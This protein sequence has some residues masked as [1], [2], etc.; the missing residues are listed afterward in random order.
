MQEHILFVVNSYPP[1]LGG[2]EKHVAS[3]AQ[4]IVAQG[5]R[6]TV[7]S[8]HDIPSDGYSSGVRV[9]TR[10]GHLNIGSVFSFP[11]LGTKKLIKELISS[12]NVTGVS[13]H[14]RFFPMSWL[15]ICAAQ[16][17]NIP[18]VITEHGSNFVTGAKRF[19]LLASRIIDWTMGRWALRRANQVLAISNE[20][21]SFVKKLSGRKAIIFNNAVETDFWH[22]QFTGNEQKLV[23][24]GRLVPDKGWKESL[25]TFDTLATGNPNIQL[26]LFGDGPEMPRLLKMVENSSVSNRIFI[27]GAKEPKVIREVLSGAVFLNPTSLSEGFQTTLLEAAISGARIVSF[28]VP[29]LDKL[30]D[31]GALIFRAENSRELISLVKTALDT[32]P[33]KLSASQEANWSWDFRA[34]EF[35]NILTQ[36]K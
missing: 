2:L 15:G 34:Q 20:S 28:P 32:K 35:T 13:V 8:I 36:I 25:E 7:I 4:K 30:T 5:N 10:R 33:Q 3:L 18:A 16:Q 11:P 6:A 26:H 19:V 21:A 14:T 31:S 27:H 12:T 17:A 29:G 24:I 22:K 23:F 1:R 9:I